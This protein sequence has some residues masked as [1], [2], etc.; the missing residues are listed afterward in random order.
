MGKKRK[1]LSSFGGHGSR[2]PALCRRLS[3]L[4]GQPGEPARIAG[5]LGTGGLGIGGLLSV[6]LCWQLCTAGGTGLI[7][8][9]FK[10]AEFSVRKG[11]SAPTAS[12]QMGVFVKIAMDLSRRAPELLV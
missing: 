9:L 8:H 11:T 12:L 10:T 6:D 7:C 4:S 2:L 1:S 5:G 3:V